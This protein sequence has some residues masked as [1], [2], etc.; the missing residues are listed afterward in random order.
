MFY[1]LFPWAPFSRH[2][3]R[4]SVPPRHLPVNMSRYPLIRR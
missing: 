1:L 2:G 3:C 4:L